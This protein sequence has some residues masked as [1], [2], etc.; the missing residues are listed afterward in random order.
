VKVNVF[1]PV[2]KLFWSISVQPLHVLYDAQ[3][4]G[5]VWPFKTM[6]PTLSS[7]NMRNSNCAVV[8]SMPGRMPNVVVK[9]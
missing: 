3:L 4:T 5:I 6:L 2:T 8:T 9:L 1:S 7:V